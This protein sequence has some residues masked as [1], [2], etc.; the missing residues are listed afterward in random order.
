MKPI[1]FRHALTIVAQP[2]NRKSKATFRQT[3]LFIQSFLQNKAMRTILNCSK[4]THLEL[5]L[6]SP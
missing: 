4:Y 2:K 3:L 5:I 1:I 6:E